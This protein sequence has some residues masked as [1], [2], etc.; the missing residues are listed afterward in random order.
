MQRV[1]E[2]ENPEQVPCLVESD[3]G[4]QSQNPE[5]MI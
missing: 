2:R 1:R 4:V 3:R 5:V